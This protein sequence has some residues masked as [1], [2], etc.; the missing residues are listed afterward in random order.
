MSA[1]PGRV[2]RTPAFEKFDDVVSAK[3]SAYKTDYEKGPK[4]NDL[5]ADAVA[6]NIISKKT[7]DHIIADW[8]KGYWPKSKHVGRV[9]QRGLYWAVR[10]ALF[11]DGDDTKPRTPPLK[12]CTAWVCSGEYGDPRFE[13]INV[14]SPSQ[15]T[16]LF[17]TP[18]PE[19]TLEIPLGPK[20]QPVW[21]TRSDDFAEEPGEVVVETWEHTLTV[22]PLNL[23][24]PE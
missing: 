16:V 19:K 12:I 15:V 1:M 17:L 13:L 9:I 24:A 18:P 8:L 6:Q 21:T 5:L 23:P 10:L 20:R 2:T 22:Q 14:V 3:L 7:H 4:I 11:V